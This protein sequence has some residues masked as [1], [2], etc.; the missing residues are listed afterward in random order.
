MPTDKAEILKRTEAA[1]IAIKAAY[2]TEDDEY[3]A[4]LFVSHHLE[5]I[6]PA[7][8]EQQF[9][10]A[11][12]EA[13]RILDALVLKSEFDDDDELDSFDFTLPGDVTDYVLCVTFDA[14]GEVEDISMES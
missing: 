12:P 5:E 3:G 4:T 1:R 7:Y 13:V 9:K 2:G 10:T 14:A 11:V 6:E 8:W